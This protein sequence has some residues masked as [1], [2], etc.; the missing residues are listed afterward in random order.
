IG[1]EDGVVAEASLSPNRTTIGFNFQKVDKPTE[2]FFLRLE[3]NE[4]V[5]VSRVNDAPPELP[6]GRTEVIRW[7]SNDGKEIEGL[8][9]YPVG[10]SEGKKCPLLL[11]IHGGPAG[12]FTRS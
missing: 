8:L 12:V 9:T 6:L 4:S 10:Y 1:P 7:P 2:A 11:V 5:Q 3:G